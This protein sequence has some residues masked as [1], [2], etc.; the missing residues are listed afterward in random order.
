M[1]PAGR[2]PDPTRRR[3]FSAWRRRSLPSDFLD[4]VKG[5]DGPLVG[6]QRLH[7]PMRQ[8]G[9]SISK[10]SVSCSLRMTLGAIQDTKG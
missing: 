9:E 5:L 8:V 1:G 7:Q 2:R 3:R 6:V 10:L 4:R